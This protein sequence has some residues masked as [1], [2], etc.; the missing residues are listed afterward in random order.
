MPH[1]VETD[2]ERRYLLRT[3]SDAEEERLEREYFA[4]ADA[5]DRITAT[6]EALIEAYLDDRLPADER[7]RFEEAY[8]S[9]NAKRLRVDTIR[10]LR[11]AAG[12]N[13]AQAP[14]SAAAFGSAAA[15]RYMPLAAAAV[16]VI[17]VLAMTWRLRDHGPSIVPAPTA[18]PQAA[19][20][21]GPASPPGVPAARPPVIVALTLSPIATRSATASR[22][23]MIPSGTDIVELELAVESSPASATRVDVTTVA[24]SQVWS[25]A[26]TAAAQRNAV[27]VQI[28]ASQ[29]A[30]DDYLVT[31]LGRTP[32]GAD[33]EQHRY[34][35]RVRA[36]EA[37]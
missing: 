13:R 2:R 24:G 8:L 28:P 32:R 3:L 30:P 33:S 29:L 10:R 27:K 26:P 35:L 31:L 4:S 7:Q 17:G 11:L 25:G 12:A 20:P 16:L 15:R 6:E 14:A 1:A 34:F 21:A 22:P 9:S 19:N 36:R 5:L 37:R 23:L 18:P